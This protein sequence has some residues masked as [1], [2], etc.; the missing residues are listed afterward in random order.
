M[1]ALTIRQPW[2]WAIVHAGK[3]VE[4]R[5]WKNRY[6]SGTIAVHAGMGLDALSAL[7]RGVKRPAPDDL[8]H[9]AIIGVVDVVGVVR[10][11]RSKWFS[12]P[13]GWVLRNARPLAKPIPCSGRLG[14]WQLPAQAH[15]AI[16][17]QL[18]T[19]RL[20]RRSSGRAARTVG[21]RGRQ[22]N[23]EK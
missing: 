12:G 22:R 1:R 11:C 18:A 14:L 3:D 9:G 6:A 7:P 5:S 23:L 21:R 20:T 10:R 4:N 19:E 2:A 15:H 8:L 16:N 17:R 13:L